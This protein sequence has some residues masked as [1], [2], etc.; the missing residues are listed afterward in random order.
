MKK[1]KV[2]D[3]KIYVWSARL[4][5]Y[6]PAQ[7]NPGAE[8]VDELLLTGVGTRMLVPDWDPSASKQ[9]A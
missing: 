1:T 5:R 2:I 3:D 6:V 9:S 8:A 7:A 4:E